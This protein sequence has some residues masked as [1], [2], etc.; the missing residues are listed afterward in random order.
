MTGERYLGMRDGDLGGK[1]YARHWNPRM[2]PL[3]PHA[4]EAL[5]AGPVAPPVSL[6]LVDARRLLDPTYDDLENGFTITPD[7]ALHVAIRT[8]MPRVTP[9]MVDW[10]FGWH[11][12][13][14]QRYKL[15]HPRA[16]VHAEWHGARPPDAARGRARYV[17][18]TSCVDE[19]LGHELGSYAIQ[20]VPPARLGLEGPEIDD[21]EKDTVVCARVGFAAHPI[22]GGYLA[23]HVMRVPGGSVMRS[24]FWIGAPYAG[25]RGNKLGA[26]VAVSVV[27]RVRRPKES[28]GRAL[29]A[30]CAQEMAHLA[31]FLPA[32]YAELGQ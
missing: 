19:Y 12:D 3:A 18:Y 23:H 20:F 28:E 25:A 16:H 15:W 1:P 13:E 29:L 8:E 21:P 5:A 26:S 7:G 10:W 17:G 4:I 24:R 32:L 31:S 27:K 6:A 14:P 30:H 9:A 22:D 2:A 11:S